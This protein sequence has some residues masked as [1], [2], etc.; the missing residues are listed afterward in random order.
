MKHNFGAGPCILPPEVFREASQAVIDFNNS[1]LSILEISHRSKAFEAVIEETEALVRDLLAVPDGYSVLFLQG[2][3]SQ[4]FAMVPMNLLPQAGKAAYLDSGTWASKAY[5]EAQKIGTIQVVASSK[6]ANYTYIPKEYTVPADA[7]YFH[8]TSNNTIYGTELFETPQSPIPL[9]CDM[10]SD[11]LSR[12]INVADYGLI[13]AGAQ[14]NM[15]P[16]GLTLVIV[17]NDI[18]GKTGK[19]IPSIFDYRKHAEAGSMYNTPPV[20]A[21]YV[22]L[23]NLRWLK[24]KGGVEEI[25]RENI[26]KAR[27]LYDEI[28]RNPLFKGTAKLEDRSRMN[29]TF[30]MENAD[31]EKSFLALT[32]ERGL[33]GLK[34]HRS[35]GGFRASIYNALTIT[36]I[37]TLVDLMQEFAEKNA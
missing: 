10:S 13:Y 29:V 32:E 17:K 16:A 24:A 9:V 37:N 12:R 4:Q 2:G 18:L 33:V 15:G 8:Y 6:E 31:L 19:D 3:A 25:E 5:K 26:I 23:L 14:K 34:G 36:S 30:V 22:S 28:D 27:T 20:Y 1:G 21:V 11:I 35:V 7:A